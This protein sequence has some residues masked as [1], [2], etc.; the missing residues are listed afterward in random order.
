MSDRT[1]RL[2]LPVRARALDRAA[3]SS[4]PHAHPAPSPSRIAIRADHKAVNITPE[5]AHQLILALR[6]RGVRYVVAPYEAD[7]QIAHLATS[8]AV[9]LVLA[10][11]SD[12][13]AFGCPRVLTKLDQNGFGRLLERS[14]LQLARMDGKDGGYPMFTPW[15][16]WESGRFLDLCILAGCDYLDSMPGVGIKSAYQLLR[17]HKSVE[18]VVRA[19][20]MEGKLARVEG[21][22]EAYLHYYAKAK[23]TFLHQR[24][25]DIKLRKVVPLT[26][27]PTGSPSMPH[28]GGDIEDELAYRLCSLGDLHPDTQQPFA[29]REAPL[30][31]TPAD[32]TPKPTLS[33]AAQTQP[34][35]SASSSGVTAAFAALSGAAAAAMRPWGGGGVGKRPEMSSSG[36]A[37]ALGK[38]PTHMK[39]GSL[40]QMRSGGGVSGALGAF[41]RAS[42]FPAA[43]AAPASGPSQGGE[44]EAPPMR[45]LYSTHASM[46]PFKMPRPSVSAAPPVSVAATPAGAQVSR[47]VSGLTRSRFFSGSGASAA[48]DEAVEVEAE[49]AEEAEATARRRAAAARDE[50]EAARDAALSSF[51]FTPSASTRPRRSPSAGASGGGNGSRGRSKLSARVHGS[52]GENC[53]PQDGA[54]VSRASTSSAVR[55]SPRLAGLQQQQ[56]HGQAQGHS[57]TTANLD[58]SAFAFAGAGSGA[59]S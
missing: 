22:A 41:V 17:K 46:K 18:M 26:P 36:G 29:V 45:P 16:E 7:A 15:S 24:V 12:M 49:E 55:S 38:R 54:G 59:A 27:Q 58:L 2:T 6:R 8:G 23:Q 28:C 44:V 31:P 11:D 39:Q 52:Y 47:H 20:N 1:T 19:L 13:L 14:K 48:R 32:P 53:P 5:H 25:Y 9:Q 4:S 3:L 30:R 51:S 37:S 35:S 43:R 34:S 10:E 50:A 42:S 21:G 56:R 33:Q 40:D 57:T